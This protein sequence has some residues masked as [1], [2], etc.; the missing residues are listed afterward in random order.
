[1][2][3]TQWLLLLV[4]VAVAYGFVVV[5][6]ESN[7]RRNVAHNAA[8]GLLLVPLLFVLAPFILVGLAA[9]LARKREWM[10][11][12]LVLVGLLGVAGYGVLVFH[13]RDRPAPMPEEL[14]VER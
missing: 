5:L 11:A 13:L 12:G 8:A 3:L 1:V 9:E 2:N 14:P 10:G 6:G 4:P 7:G